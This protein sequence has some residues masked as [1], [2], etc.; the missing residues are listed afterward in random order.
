[1]DV[2]LGCKAEAK[3][4]QSVARKLGLVPRTSGLNIST[5]VRKKAFS[6]PTTLIVDASYRSR[7]RHNEAAAYQ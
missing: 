5:A 1:M 7:R 4:E 3:L 6:E 2:L